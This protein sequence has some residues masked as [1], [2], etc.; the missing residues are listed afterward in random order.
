MSSGDDRNIL[1]VF[2]A[3][4]QV[5]PEPPAP[6]PGT[7]ENH[8]EVLFY[9]PRKNACLMLHIRASSEPDQWQ[10]KG[11]GEQCHCGSSDRPSCPVRYKA[12]CDVFSTERLWVYEL[13]FAFIYIRYTVVRDIRNSSL[14]YVPSW[15]K[16]AVAWVDSSPLRKA[17]SCAATSR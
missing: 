8:F 2:V 5:F 15:T 7:L 16:E 6:S 11:G 1:K 12:C 13:S 14:L 4:R 10:S 17:V 3:G 9:I